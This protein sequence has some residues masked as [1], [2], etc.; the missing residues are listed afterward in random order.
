MFYRGVIFDRFYARGGGV[1]RAAL[2]SSVLFGG[3]HLLL[4]LLLGEDPQIR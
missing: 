4:R 3:M 2:A 1:H